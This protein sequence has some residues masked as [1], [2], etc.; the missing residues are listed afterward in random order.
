MFAVNAADSWIR[1]LHPYGNSG[2]DRFLPGD[3]T[4]ERL[5][6]VLKALQSTN[7]QATAVDALLSV[8]KARGLAAARI[9]MERDGLGTAA[10]DAIQRNL[11]HAEIRDCSNLIRLIRMVKSSEELRRV[12]RATEVG[13][14]A[15]MEALHLAHPGRPMS[16][17]IHHFQ[18]R[19]AEL[20]ADFD[21]FA[22]G[23][24]GLG[25]AMEPGYILDAEDVMYIDYGCVVGH[26]YS[27]SGLTL[28]LREPPGEISERYAALRSCVE[29]GAA[30]LRPGA[31]AS[32]VQKEMVKILQDKGVTAALANGH[33]LGLEVRDYPI[34]VP[35]N[36]L[37][38]QDDCVDQPSD[39]L[40]ESNM[41][42]NLESAIFMPGAGSL[43]IEKSY[44]TVESGS[45]ELVRQDRVKP[46]MPTSS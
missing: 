8:L 35:D 17:L 15:A 29:A 41:V 5:Q 30:A 33:G 32:A 22:F 37:R 11:P 40:L 13:E 7:N 14:V 21:H 2:L 31:K 16:D 26:Y 4:P 24:R 1:D 36:G 45:R 39:L 19:V 44:L 18:V 10:S 9:G 42:L 25:I 6:H 27:D 43:Q 23:I 38:I 46:V 28:A 34:L 3:S 12:T 20:G